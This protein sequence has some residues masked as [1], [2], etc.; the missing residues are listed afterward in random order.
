MYSKKYYLCEYNRFCICTKTFANILAKIFAK[1]SVIFVIKVPF[2][3]Y[4]KQKCDNHFSSH[5]FT[6]KSVWCK[7]YGFD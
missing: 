5:W 2:G 6:H 1:T 4:Q 7:Q 3:F